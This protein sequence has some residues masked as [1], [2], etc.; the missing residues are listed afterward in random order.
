MLVRLVL[1]PLRVVLP[2]RKAE[3]LPPRAVLPL[4]KVERLPLMAALLPRKVELLP[5]RMVLPLRK[6][7]PSM[8]LCQSS[9]RSGVSGGICGNATGRC[10]N[11]LIV[12]RPHRT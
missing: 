8:C 2:L 6:A 9:S 7:E 1:L 3:L 10:K 11:S 4:R 5:P 12:S